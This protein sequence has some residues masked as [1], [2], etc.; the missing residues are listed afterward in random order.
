MVDLAFSEIAY[1]TRKVRDGIDTT[2][3]VLHSTRLDA[4]L[5]KDYLIEGLATRIA[6]HPNGQIGIGL[7]KLGGKTNTL[8]SSFKHQNCLG[9]GSLMESDRSPHRNDARAS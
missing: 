7:C 1:C 9:L 5:L 3:I 6:R 8:S 2:K 4:R